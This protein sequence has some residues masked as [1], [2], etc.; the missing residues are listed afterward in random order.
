MTLGLSRNVDELHLPRTEAERGNVAQGFH[1]WGQQRQS[2]KIFTKCQHQLLG[3]CSVTKVTSM[4]ARMQKEEDS[5]LNNL[6]LGFVKK[7]PVVDG[8]HLRWTEA[9]TNDVVQGFHLH[10]QEPTTV[11]KECQRHFQEGATA[12]GVRGTPRC[13]QRKKDPWLDDPDSNHRNAADDRS[14]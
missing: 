6:R 4:L 10:G 2:V 13:T 11:F 1:L 7:S 8:I 9:E 12:S 14:A 3:G 5:W